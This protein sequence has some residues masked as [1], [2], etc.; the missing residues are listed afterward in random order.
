M[1]LI[2]SFKEPCVIMEKR[3]FPDGEGGFSV[4]WAEG[5]EFEAAVT[6]DTTLQA[7]AAEKQGVTST[8]KVTTDKKVGL[9]FH[10]VIKRLRTG[11]YLRVTSDSEDKQTPDVSTLDFEQVTAEEWR[12]V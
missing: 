6:H 11:N 1:T 4:E 2:D 5:A 7:M 3:R 8:Y 10:D 9:V 12:L